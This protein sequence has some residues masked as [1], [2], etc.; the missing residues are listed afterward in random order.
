MPEGRSGLSRS[1][2][3]REHPIPPVPVAGRCVHAWPG[4]GTPCVH[5]SRIRINTDTEINGNEKSG[6][7]SVAEKDSVEP[8]QVTSPSWSFLQ[9]VSAAQSLS[10]RAIGKREIGVP[11]F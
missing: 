2:R 8:A 9:V 6:P 11:D 4:C 5:C 3:D 10:A 7:L 1:R